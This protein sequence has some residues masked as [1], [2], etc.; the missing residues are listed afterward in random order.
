MGNIKK[1][2]NLRSSFKPARQKQAALLAKSP[3][4]NLGKPSPL[5]HEYGAAHVHKNIR[6]PKPEGQ[7]GFDVVEGTENEFMLIDE[8]ELQPIEN[9][10][11]NRFFNKKVVGSDGNKFTANDL[12]SD[13]SAQISDL[14]NRGGITGGTFG[15]ITGSKS[16]F[17]KPLSIKYNNYSNSL[18]GSLFGKSRINVSDTQEINFTQP[19]MVF[20]EAT[21]SYVYPEGGAPVIP[22]NQMTPEQ[23]EELLRSSGG[24]INFNP[25]TG[26]LEGGTGGVIDPNSPT[27][28]GRSSVYGYTPR[29]QDE[30]SPAAT[31]FYQATSGN[32]NNGGRYIQ[33]GTTE[34]T[35]YYTDEDYMT[36]VNAANLEKAQGQLGRYRNLFNIRGCDNPRNSKSRGCQE[37]KRYIMETERNIN[38]LQQ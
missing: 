9:Y 16:Q 7:R 38:S 25:K 6:Q 11:D 31:N 12:I 32:R 23:V 27:A 14:Y 34:Y 22:E 10:G 21:N 35:S 28:A 15:G 20:D 19:E 36:N 1:K 3:L 13:Y 17:K 5:N 33:P 29:G 18:S 37:V 2:F 30:I 24:Y 8:Q 26:M 4:Y